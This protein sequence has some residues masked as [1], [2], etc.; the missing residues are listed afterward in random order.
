MEFDGAKS[1]IEKSELEI[2]WQDQNKKILANEKFLSD[3]GDFFS[4][5]FCFKH[6]S[7]KGV[8]RLDFS[9]FEL[10]HLTIDHTA[11]LTL[12]G[13]SYPIS[14]KEYAKLAVTHTITALSAGYARGVYQMIV[15]LAGLLN[16]Q[17]SRSI[18][19]SSIEDFHLSYLTQVINERGRFT[20]LR[21]EAF[22]TSYKVNFVKIREIMQ[23]LGV[24]G[25]IDVSLTTRNFYLTL[26]N[27]CQAI[28]GITL[29]EYKE[30]GSFNFLTLELG[31]YY[32]DYMKCQYEDNYLYS[33]VCQQAIDSVIQK[34]DIGN[35]KDS[36]SRNIWSTVLL[37]TIQGGFIPNKRSHKSSYVTRDKLNVEMDQELFK[38][39][40]CYFEKVQSMR[41]KNIY[42]VVKALGLGMRFDAVEVIRILMLQKHYPFPTNTSPEEVW[43][44]YLSS[45]DKTHIDSERLNEVTVADVYSRMLQI[46]END[47]LDKAAFMADLSKWSM[48]LIGCKKKSGISQLTKELERVS[49][50]MTSLV[51]AWLGYRKS[52]FGFPLS[53]I[54]VE[55]NL[56]ILDSSYVPF[57]FKLKWLV[58]K[59]NGKTKID[60]EIIS[61]CYQ[62][63]AQLNEL[64]QSPEGSPCL[65]TSTGSF[66]CKLVSSESVR[67]IESRVK[68]N[69]TSFVERYQPFVDVKELQRLSELEDATI[70]SDEKDKLQKLRVIY[71]LSSARVR[72][73]LETCDEVRGDIL[74]LDCT[75]FAG[76][77]QAKFKKS[78]I[79]FNKTGDISNPKHK[80]IV[81]KHLSDVTKKWLLSESMNLDQKGM[82]DITNEILQGVRYPTAHAFRHI[83]AEAVLTRYQGDVGAVIR[84]HFCHLDESFFMAYLRNKEPKHLIKAARIKVLNSI[85]DSLLIDSKKIGREYLGGFARFVKK[86]AISTKAIT[87]NEIRELRERIVGRVIS[88]QPSHFATCIPREGAESRAKCAM[89][90]DINPQNAKPAFCLGCA[91]ALI[92]EGNLKGIW[93]TIQP[94]VKESLNES[95]MGFMVEQHLPMLRSGFKRVKELQTENNTESVSK[96]L[97][98]INKAIQSIEKKLKEEEG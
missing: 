65:Y 97:H 84:H 57:R 4:D 56:D 73:L 26:D 7:G 33:I 1:E 38:R 31:Q 23:S 67:Y 64:F 35:I 44:T 58:P 36:K 91:N 46:V 15:H 43:I 75:G 3:R 61:N 76:K 32:V 69:W 53:A 25:L 96:I 94:F 52:E 90:G 37:D 34:F 13:N 95:V 60:R 85:V 19:S 39:Y 62:V 88:I 92:T 2:F 59:T 98:M 41:D 66:K 11:T 86:A 42:Q 77:G 8:H 45:L 55:P 22:R 16:A 48:S 29:S 30:G 10:P 17:Q 51:V 49:D 54:H 74:K 71:D 50:A 9:I 82:V 81:N 63:A 79:E 18:T 20:R 68:S 5:V 72:K 47:R 80:D 21:P 12:I 87:E 89:F 70:S 78:L 24:L 83:W 40:L 27:A 28:M 6:S 93:L 14:M